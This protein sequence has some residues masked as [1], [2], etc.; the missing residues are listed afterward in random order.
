MT[1]TRVNLKTVNIMVRVNSDGVPT[2]NFTIRV[3][4]NEERCMVLEFSTTLMAFLRE[5]SDLASLR[6]KLWPLFVMGIATLENSTIP[7]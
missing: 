2:P 7:K 1:L 3:N 6:A 4:S 5:I